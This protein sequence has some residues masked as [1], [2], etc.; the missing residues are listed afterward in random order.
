MKEL[1]ENPKMKECFIKEFTL[2]KPPK[3]EI[4]GKILS[5]EFSRLPFLKQLHVEALKKFNTNKAEIFDFLNEIFQAYT[6]EDI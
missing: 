3:F 4:L 2:E 1:S 5:Y 6:L